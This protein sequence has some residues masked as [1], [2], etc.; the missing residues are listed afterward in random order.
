MPYSTRALFCILLLS[1]F[2]LFSAAQD[3]PAISIT[4]ETG[5]V[6]TA[7]IMIEISGLEAQTTVTIEFVFADEVVFSSEETS[8][9]DGQISFQAGSTEGDLPGAYT[10]Q[11]LRDGEVLAS[12]EFELTARQDDGLPGQVSVSPAQGPIGTVHTVAITALEPQTQYTVAI[13]AD[14]TLIVGYRRQH[15]SDDDGAIEIEVFAEVGDSPGPQAIAVRDDE[16]ELV[17]QGEFTIDAPPERDVAVVVQ[18]PAAQAGQ[19]IEIQLTG[20]APFDHISAEIMSA[21]GEPVENLTARASN[22][23]EATLTFE[24][25]DDLA[26]GAY[27][28]DIRVIDTDEALASASLEILAETP[29]ADEEAPNEQTESNDTDDGPAIASASIEPQ[30]ALIGSSHVITVRDL[31]PDETVTFDVTFEGR[32]VYR[33]EKTADEDGVIRLELVTTAGD[34]AGDYIVSVMR[35][36]GAGPS[37]TLT[38]IREA[39]SDISSPLVASPGEVIRGQLING[40]AALD[41]A[42]QAGQYLLIEVSADDFDPAATLYDP[43][44]FAITFNDDSRLRKDP[45]IGPLRVTE[46]G[47]YALEV[48]PSPSTNSRRVIEGEFTVTVRTVSVASIAYDGEIDFALNAD[49]P[50]IYYELPV[51]TGDS[52]T[53]SIDSGGEL[54]TMMQLIAPD[55]FELAFDDD[56]GAGFDAEFSNLIFDRTATYILA[57]TSFS[58]DASGSG[59]IRVTRNPV[60]ALEDGATIINLSDKLIRDLVIF[61]AVADEML[62]LNLEKLDGDVEDLFV[63]ATVE[64]MEVMSYSTMGVPDDLPL[65]FVMPMSGRVVVTLEKFGQDDGI[66]LSVSLERP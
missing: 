41:I 32:S 66:S 59:T 31:A 52:L 57:L 11:V 39:A 5:E 37:V 2:A 58:G 65:A 3:A 20:L 64:G 28:I 45:S 29:A 4:P 15:I 49:A 61:D 27:S 56:G 9:D 36:A 23:G 1:L 17:A 46:S 30:S 47:Q 21:D 16:G 8:D 42:A 18:P 10:V 7:L 48:S 54:D 43:D 13:T 63:T 6:E 12:A 60:R 40:S 26:L 25:S 38:A 34:K 33:T 51:E 22:A 14:E 35:E 55:G 19:A 44:G 53:I 62:I 24:S 50:T